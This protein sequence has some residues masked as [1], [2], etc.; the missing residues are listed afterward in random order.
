MQSYILVLNKKADIS[1]VEQLALNS[2]FEIN[3]LAEMDKTASDKAF[4]NIVKLLKNISTDVEVKEKVITVDVESA[5]ACMNTKKKE[6]IEKVLKDAEKAADEKSKYAFLSS[7]DMVHFSNNEDILVYDNSNDGNDY[8]SSLDDFIAY[9][10]E[11]KVKLDIR[12]IVYYF[13]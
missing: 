9:A 3:S 2:E 11:E 12:Q 6:L 1:R 13:F 7:V 10:D 8:L 5:L 4:E